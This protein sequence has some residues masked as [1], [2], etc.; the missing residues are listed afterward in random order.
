MEE[1]DI[2][3]IQYGYITDPSNIAE[4]LGTGEKFEEWAEQGS[5]EDIEYTMKVFEGEELYEHCAVLLKIL[6]RKKGV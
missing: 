3:I 1:K 5:V 6:N 2:L 4:I